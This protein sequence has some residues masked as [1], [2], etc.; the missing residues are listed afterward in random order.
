MPS[1]RLAVRYVCWGCDGD[2]EVTERDGL[3]DD[4]EVACP[5]CGSDLAAAD[6]VRRSRPLR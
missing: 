5:A 1:R 6:S 3:T 2:F 4:L